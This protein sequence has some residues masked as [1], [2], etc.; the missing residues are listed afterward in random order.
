MMSTTCG[1]PQLAARS[2]DSS[3]PGGVLSQVNEALIAR[4]PPN[5]FV[6]CFYAILDPRSG[7]LSYANAGHDIPYLHRRNGEVEELRARGMPLGLMPGMGYEEK[8][9]TLE[10]PKPNLGEHTSYELG[11]QGCHPGEVS[12]VGLFGPCCVRWTCIW[13]DRPY[14]HSGE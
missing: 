13:R 5:M 10:D 4:I 11:G 8:E 6:A 1:M 9:V 14:E 2:V 7:S 12:L 3:S